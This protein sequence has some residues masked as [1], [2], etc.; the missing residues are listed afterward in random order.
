MNATLAVARREFAEKRFVLV[1]AVVLAF[2]P[3]LI[4]LIPTVRQF[5]SHQV[6]VTTAAFLSVGF[7]W[8]LAVILGATVIGRELS[9]RRLSFYFARPISPA[10]IWFGKMTASLAMVMLTFAILFG[11][12]IAF[13]A[14]AWGRSWNVDLPV[15]VA[16]VFVVAVVLLFLTHALAT[17]TRSRSPLVALDFVLLIVSL[18]VCAG[19]VV[20]L[21]FTFATTLTVVVA[22]SLGSAFVAALIGAGWYQVAR[23][24]V[25]RQQ[26]HRALS[27]AL[28]SSFGCV[29]VIA[30]AYVAWVLSAKPAD[31]VSLSQFDQP[32]QGPWFAVGGRVRHRLDFHPRFVVNAETGESHRIG[33]GAW[34]QGLN[35]FFSP[36]GKTVG[37]FESSLT[38][39]HYEVV[40][41]P[42]GDDAKRID[43]GIPAHPFGDIAMT[44]DASH[45]ATFADVISIWDVRQHKLIGSLRPPGGINRWFS[46][47]TDAGHLRLIGVQSPKSPVLRDTVVEHTIRIFEYDVAKRSLANLGEGHITARNVAMSANGDG[48]L[49]ML[50]AFG[51]S[52]RYVVMDGRTGAT[53]ASI[54]K[55]GPD[56][57]GGMFR[58]LSNGVIAVSEHTEHDSLLR[59]YGIDGTLRHELKL[60]GARLPIVGELAPGK[61]AV[62]AYRGPNAPRGQLKYWQ[63]MLID[64]TNG[65]VVAKADGLGP[66]TADWFDNGRDPRRGVRTSLPLF[67]DVNQA[68]VTWNPMTGAR[69]VVLPAGS[70]RQE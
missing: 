23:G 40:L 12:A 28:W 55:A 26:S 21:M 9:E 48:S 32:P 34:R 3:F 62:A 20:T 70:A 57:M 63:T 11:P 10:A 33:G 44:N 24:R 29:L 13:A 17:M 30:L 7:A 14:S 50:R 25:E 61:L 2:V 64:S 16:A 4:T 19:I 42:L 31:L 58:I 22:I 56:T 69:K 15:F 54:V 67:I 49:L 41:M 53:L 46:F 38:G 8:G 27:F 66:M 1:A 51:S 35:S 39:K 18:L 60:P 52:T 6:L 45:L 59:F 37:W 43:T 65:N 5:G 36:D 47:F 68:L